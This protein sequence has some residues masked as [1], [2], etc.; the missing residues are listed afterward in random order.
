MALYAGDLMIRL[1]VFLL[2]PVFAG[3]AFA[4]APESVQLTGE[5]G[6]S[7]HAVYTPAEESKRGVIFLHMV[8]R[9]AKDW[10][11][12]AKRVNRAGFHTL[13][14][15][16]RNHGENAVEGRPVEDLNY[17]DYRLM[18]GDLVETLAWFRAKGV[19]EVSLVGASVGSNLAMIV[20]KDDP[21]IHNVVLL[22]PGLEFKGLEIDG[23]VAAYG[24]RPL[25][26]AVSSE[27]KY[28]ARSA[29]VLDA[30]ALGKHHLAVYEKAGHGTKMLN[31]AP[32]LEPLVQSWLLGTW[33]VSHGT[34]RVEDRLK[35]GDT[36]KQ[37]TTGKKFGEE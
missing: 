12:L 6:I 15:D 32:A 23:A 25:L 17:H 34:E 20:A 8:G 14:V 13:A 37:E 4:G 30:E 28:S 1:L 19:E 35:T 29:L 11:Y 27:D 7:L 9:S 33:G 22:S 18:V 5:E 26:I 10:S 24:E 3:A 2:S 31:R 21:A 16:L 36:T